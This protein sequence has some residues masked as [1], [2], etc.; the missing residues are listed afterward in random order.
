MKSGIVC[1]LIIHV[2]H[3]DLNGFDSSTRK[4]QRCSGVKAMRKEASVEPE[5]STGSASL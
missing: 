4:I 3:T 5:G 1:P 2:I